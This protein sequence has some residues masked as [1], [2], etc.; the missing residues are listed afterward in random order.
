MSRVWL[1]MGGN[2]WVQPLKQGLLQGSANSAKIFASVLDWFLGP[3][4]DTWDRKYPNSWVTDGS[5][6]LHAILYADDLLLVATSLS[7]AQEKLCDL[8]AQL[9]AIGLFLSAP[10]CKVMHSAGVQS[11]FRIW[12]QSPG[13]PQP[14][15]YE[16]PK[17]L[18]RLLQ[19]PVLGKDT[20][21]EAN[22]SSQCIYNI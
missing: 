15:H 21:A 11:H 17:F 13:D 18:L 10:K 1:S 16:G 8:Q 6:I 4:W 12:N 22:S 20:S 2:S 3:L 14:S 7:E 9:Q 5:R 19:N